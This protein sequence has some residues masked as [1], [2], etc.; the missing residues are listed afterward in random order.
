MPPTA[1][2]CPVTAALDADYAAQAGAV[3]ALASADQLHDFSRRYNV[4]DGLD[5]LQAVI[6]HPHCD[7]GTAL[8]I[9]WQ[10]HELLADAQARSD[11]ARESPRWNAAAL[12]GTIEQRYPH[13]FAQRGIAYDP[14]QL[15]LD[16]GELAQIHAAHAGSPL[17]QP[18]R[19]T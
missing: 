18:L 14:A 17:L 3:A 12:L 4:N 16:S 6:A 13:G 11:S 15:G 2:P 9:Y 7:A 1:V 10:F 8:Y 19:K 5:P